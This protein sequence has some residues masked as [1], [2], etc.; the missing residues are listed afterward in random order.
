MIKVG[1]VH[2]NMGNIASVLNSLSFLGLAAEAFSD[3]DKIGYFDKIILPGVGA[4]P[5]A[6][7][8]LKQNGFDEAIKDFVKTKAALGVCLGM[9]LLFDRSFE[10][11][12]TAGLGL[13]GGDV[14][15]FDEKVSGNIP[16]MGWNKINIKRKTPILKEVSDGSYLYFV[17]S[18]YAKPY[19]EKDIIASTNYGVSFV[20]IV[21]KDNI[22]GI[23]PHPEKS[24]EVGLK[25]IKNFLEI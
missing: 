21:G 3:P 4:F 15:R 23:Q 6:M 25:I 12:E 5:D 13:I 24:G 14:V 7:G 18:Y 17:H 2:Y 10:H 22:F 19:D 11:G 8:H 1:V 9:Q 16:Q 20:S